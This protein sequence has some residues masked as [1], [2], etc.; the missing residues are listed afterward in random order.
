[1]E[2]IAEAK[3]HLNANYKEGVKCPCCE[4]FVKEY[5]RSI[6]ARV[7][8]LLIELY[9]ID[10][11]FAGPYRYVHIDDICRN[12]TDKGS[13]DFAKL[14]FWG[15]VHLEENEDTKKKTSGK[16]MITETGKEFVLRKRSVQKYVH[17]LLN[18][19]R[20]FSGPQVTID[21]CLGKDFDYAELMRL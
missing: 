8:R 12:V 4:Q 7:A 9:K 1:M 10:Y 17:I 21:D 11:T 13:G 2:T 15:L 20:K 3:A 19:V 14:Q 5:K 16:W 18:K 6:Y